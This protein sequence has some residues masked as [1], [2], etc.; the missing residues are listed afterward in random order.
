MQYFY[1]N[2]CKF[3]YYF[4]SSRKNSEN[5]ITDSSAKLHMGDI[6]PLFKNNYESS[7][8]TYLKLRKIFVQFQ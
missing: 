8:L 5:S 1:K 3:V 2:A 6:T 7:V 4:L